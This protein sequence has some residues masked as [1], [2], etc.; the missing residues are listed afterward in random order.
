MTLRPNW[1]TRG[2]KVL[3]IW[4]PPLGMPPT[5]ALVGALPPVPSVFAGDGALGSAD[6]AG[7][8]EVGVVEDVVELGAELHLQALDRRR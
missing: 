4:P 5:M 8:V 7:K 6:G 3:V 1:R 2:S